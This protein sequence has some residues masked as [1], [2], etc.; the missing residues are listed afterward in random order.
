MWKSLISMVRVINSSFL[1]NLFFN[2]AR[3]SVSCFFYYEEGIFYY[4]SCICIAL[5]QRQ[6]GCSYP[7]RRG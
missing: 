2:I 4:F 3:H 7:F 1:I 5:L 6:F